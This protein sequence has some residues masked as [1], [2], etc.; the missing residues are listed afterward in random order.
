MER[1]TLPVEEW[2]PGAITSFIAAIIS[3]SI[4]VIEIKKRNQHHTKFTTKSLEYSS[5][6]CIIAACITNIFF[7]LNEVHGFCSIS[8]F[9]ANTTFIISSV[10]M[11]F[12]QLSRLH[13]CFANSK[14][15]SN[16]GYPKWTFIIMIIIGI[17]IIFLWPITI[18]GLFDVIYSKCGITSEFEFYYIPVA[19]FL[20]EHAFIWLNATALLFFSWD[21][22]TLLLFYCKIRSFRDVI[23]DKNEFVYKRVLFILYHIFIVTMFYEMIYVTWMI[24]VSTLS[25]LIDT[26]WV[27]YL[28]QMMSLNV[29]SVCLSLAMFLMMDHN[30][31]AYV[32]FLKIIYTLKLH[33][34]C[35]S[36]KSIVKEHLNELDIA[37]QF[38]KRA[39]SASMDLSNDQNITPSSIFESS[40]ISTQG[41]KVTANV[42]ELS[43]N[44]TNVS[45]SLD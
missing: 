34:I 32:N 16:K 14:I 37:S 6:I 7:T 33:W 9:I 3:A 4:F 38:A 18:M 39:K 42:M 43:V 30:E 29:V 11:G 8:T 17:F 45:N 2:L 27:I 1:V 13:Y 20:F 44:T 12:Y 23:K 25:M 35:C 31:G 41:P 40:N 28:M 36:C 21:I 22:A 19:T 10:F 24:F 15:H 26:I 5:L